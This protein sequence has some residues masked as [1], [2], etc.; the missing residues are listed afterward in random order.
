MAD[1]RCFENGFIAT[2]W[3]RII[4][5]QWNLMQMQILMPKRLVT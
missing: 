2:F 3:P 4:C 5:F 1:G